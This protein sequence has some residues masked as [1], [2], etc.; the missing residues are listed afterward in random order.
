[1]V[2]FRFLDLVGDY[3]ST[4]RVLAQQ[5]K[6]RAAVVHLG[7]R[8]MMFTN[9]EELIR[10]AV[11]TLRDTSSCQSSG[12]F[13]W[14]QSQPGVRVRATAGVDIDVIDTF[15]FPEFDK[16]AM[17]PTDRPFLHYDDIGEGWSFA[18]VPFRSLITALIQGRQRSFGILSM[19]SSAPR[20]FAQNDVEFLQSVAVLVATALE[21][22]E[23]EVEIRQAQKSESIGR[24]AAGVAH[25]INTPVQVVSTN[26]HFVEDGFKEIIAARE[27]LRSAFGEIAGAAEL[28]RIDR[29]HDVDFF[30]SEL[31]LALHDVQTNLDRTASIVRAM[32]AF[33]AIEKVGQADID[34]NEIVRNTLIVTAQQI[35]KV[36]DVET[37]LGE[38]AAIREDPGD[39]NQVVLNVL[40]NAVHAIEDRQRRDA[41]RGKILLRT[42]ES[43]DRVMFT[44]TDDGVGIADENVDRV[45]DP[46]FTTKDVGRGAGQG[47]TFAQS[48]LKRSGGS[49]DFTTSE[50]GTAFSL[51]LPAIK[52]TPTAQGPLVS[53]GV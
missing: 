27:A 33:G 2:L 11:D 6:Y 41:R 17:D 35:D 30:V 50:N 3:G 32:T 28:Q 22:F 53:N 16:S 52:A 48:V 26:M 8:V 12:F 45:F 43:D 34:I 7:Q 36:A 19:W 4:Q 13:E 42:W 37:D 31:P 39:M 10:D 49:I 51:R 5:T 14:D 40:I 47:L 18:E 20:S 24:L 21:R 46:F 44:V 23:L 25:E 38:I 15:V 29:E 1:L 9:A